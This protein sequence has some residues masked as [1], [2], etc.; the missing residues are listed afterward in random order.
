M[1]SKNTIPEVI[2]FD[3]IATPLGSMLVCATVKGICLLDFL[4]KETID[5]RL[6]EVNKES[7]SDMVRGQ[8][9]F[10]N[11]LK[12]QLLEYFD[13]KRKDFS[14]PLDLSGTDFQM[15]VWDSLLKIPYGKV[16]SYKQQATFLGSSKS[17]RAVA[18]ANGMNKISI[19]IPCHRVIGSNGS[20]TGYAGGL[21][22][23]KFLLDLEQK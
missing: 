11:I 10:I 5:V 14:V 20:L 3:T 12:E 17:V 21:W 22:R 15:K 4:E 6:K 19:L 1:Y 23:K 7:K 13:G 8:N 9:P 2:D 16:W 18:K